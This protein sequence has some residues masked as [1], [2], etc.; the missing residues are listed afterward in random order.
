ME[1]LN[2]ERK[3][4]CVYWLLCVCVVVKII[5][6][7]FLEAFQINY[8]KTFWFLFSFVVFARRQQK[9]FNSKHSEY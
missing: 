8:F 7:A 1:S 2:T 6:L 3:N 4:E 5:A 9:D